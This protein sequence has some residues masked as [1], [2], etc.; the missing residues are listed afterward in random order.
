VPFHPLILS[1]EFKGTYY[2]ADE[3]KTVISAVRA[4]YG[5]RDQWAAFVAPRATALR[6]H[7]AREEAAQPYIR[8]LVETRMSHLND[9]SRQRDDRKDA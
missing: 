6:E 8:W 4:M 7:N 2:L 9:Q 5:K 3:A 1:S